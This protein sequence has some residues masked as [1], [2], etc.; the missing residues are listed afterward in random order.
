MRKI[1]RRSR[2]IAATADRS[3]HPLL[4]FFFVSLITVLALIEADLH[5][6]TLKSFHVV[7][8]GESVDGSFLGP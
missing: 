8:S 6:E 4:V 5:R 1:D 3:A 7:V 2:C